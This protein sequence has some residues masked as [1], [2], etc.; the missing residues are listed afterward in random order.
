MAHALAYLE[1]NGLIHR[2]IKPSNIFLSASNEYILGDLGF[3]KFIRTTSSVET[4]YNIG[5]PLYMS[6]EA[7]KNNIYSHKSDIWS[8]G[9]CAME[10]ICGKRP[11]NGVTFDEMVEQVCNQKLYLSLPVSD[12]L[13]DVIGLMLAFNC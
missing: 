6:P 8:L 7:Y 9:I 13:K 2:D 4:G 3:C 11:F 10:L 1:Q 12:K 5:S